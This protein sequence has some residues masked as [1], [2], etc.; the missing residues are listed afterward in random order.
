[1]KHLI[2]HIQLRQR[3]PTPTYTALLAISLVPLP[4]R[5]EDVVS[6]ELKIQIEAGNAAQTTKWTEAM[7][8]K[9]QKEFDSI[10]GCHHCE[11]HSQ[12]CLCSFR[13]H[14]TPTAQRSLPRRLL[15]PKKKFLCRA[16]LKRVK[17]RTATQSDALRPII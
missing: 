8:I 3:S 16:F 9:R 13:A 7:L 1:M 12:H 5:P 2:F 14:S 17:R 15:C 10:W 11:F 6:S 4:Y